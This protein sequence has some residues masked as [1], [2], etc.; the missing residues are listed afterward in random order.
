MALVALTA[1]GDAQVNPGVDHAPE[2]FRVF[3][4]RN[5]DTWYT[6]VKPQPGDKLY[7]SP[8]ARVRIW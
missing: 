4:V 7:L 1:A 2:R 6:A 5:I 3:T 8:D